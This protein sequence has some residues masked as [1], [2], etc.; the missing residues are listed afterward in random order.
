MA[1]MRCFSESSIKESA[2]S[3]RASKGR[4]AVWEL[5]EAY[6]RPR[7]RRSV[8]KLRSEVVSRV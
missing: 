4:G 5:G 2:L 7:A 1:L 6:S 8:A 3:A